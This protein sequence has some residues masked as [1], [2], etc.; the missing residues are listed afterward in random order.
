[1]FADDTA[2]FVEDLEAKRVVMKIL[3]KY[4]ST[5]NALVNVQKLVKKPLG[6][7]AYHRK[8]PNK[9]IPWMSSVTDFKYLGRPVALH[10]D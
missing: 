3:K 10:D 1:M 4:E 2:I 8:E 6:I 7:T 5:S 9:N